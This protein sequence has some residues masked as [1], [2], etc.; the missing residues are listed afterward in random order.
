MSGRGP[1]WAKM[2][3]RHKR[4]GVEY[5]HVTRTHEGVTDEE[6]ATELN[7]LHELMQDPAYS[8]AS[9]LRAEAFMLSDSAMC[10]LGRFDLKTLEL[11]E[12][13]PAAKASAK[14]KQRL[15]AILNEAADL[16]NPTPSLS[17]SSNHD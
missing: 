4:E 12:P 16:L 9:R 6:V 14:G 17:G 7:H 13:T 15:A 8:M 2:M 11:L 5:F 10:E 3:E 1:E